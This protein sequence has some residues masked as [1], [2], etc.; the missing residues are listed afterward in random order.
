MSF[1]AFGT[2]SQPTFGASTTTN[3]FGGFRRSS[4]RARSARRARLPSARPRRREDLGRVPSAPPPRRR[5]ARPRR[6][7]EVCLAPPQRQ[8]ASASGRR[9]RVPSARRSRPTRQVCSARRRRERVRV[10]DDVCVRAD[11]HLAVRRDPATEG[12]ALRPDWSLWS[13]WRGLRRGAQAQPGTGQP[14]YQPH[15]DQEQNTSGKRMEMVYHCIT[16]NPA[17]R[18]K[19]FE[20]LRLE[21]YKQGNKGR[22]GAAPAAGSFGSSPTTGAFGSTTTTTRRPLERLHLHRGL[23][24]PRRSARP[25]PRPADSS[26]A[27]RHRRPAHSAQQPSDRRRRR[28]SARR[29]RR[30]L[31]GCSGPGAGARR[32][33]G[34]QLPAGSSAPSLPG[35][36]LAA[37][38]HRRRACLAL[39]R[40]RPAACSESTPAP[41]PGAFGAAPAFGATN[42]TGGGLF[43]APKPPAELIW[44]AGART[45]RLRRHRARL[46]R[47]RGGARGRFSGRRCAGP[48]T[49]WGPGACAWRFWRRSGVWRPEARGRSLRCARARARRPVR[50]APRHR[51]VDYSARR[52]P[53]PRGLRRAGGRR[54]VRGGPETR[55]GL[56]GAPARPLGALRVHAG[57]GARRV[58]TGRHG[59]VRRPVRREAGRRGIVRRAGPRSR[60][61]VQRT[62]APAPGGGLFGSSP[63]G[64]FGAPSTGLFGGAAASPSA[65]SSSSSRWSHRPTAPAPTA[66]SR[67]SR[68]GPPRSRRGSGRPWSASPRPRRRPRPP[69]ASRT[70]P[71]SA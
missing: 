65:R 55:G 10:D 53:P 1:G 35:G 64:A 3:A 34:L 4:R 20:E 25:R 37:P 59:D 26:G 22:G 58:L 8:A 68:S 28:R 39:R 56:F 46:R 19:S 33:S 2:P 45:G 15:R 52:R 38:R 9:R 30:P 50:G 69:I 51:P 44:R 42:T 18:A 29:R 49:F 71:R 12:V 36:S 5:S 24:E 14:P 32:R 27:P 47:A 7:P 31:A 48:R 62:P 6:R 67:R 57:A 63:T 70:A 16:T 43:G 40:R 21:D 17:Y 61:T 41:A 66:A 54:A 13:D 60:R 23:S 11:H